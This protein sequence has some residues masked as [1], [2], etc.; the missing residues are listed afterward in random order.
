[1]ARRLREFG[2]RIALGARRDD[3]FRIVLQQ[4][5]GLVSSG[6]VLG[7]ILAT[8]IAHVLSGFLLGVPAL[9]PAIL[10]GAV[11]LFMSVGL[12][13]CYGPARRATNVDPLTT[14]RC[15]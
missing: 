7:V 11:A 15:D 8:A 1:V 9:D 4:G 3:I 2:I 13:A 10:A 6:C 5:L 12:A 14:L